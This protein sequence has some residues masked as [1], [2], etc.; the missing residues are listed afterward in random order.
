MEDP[1]STLLGHTYERHAIETWLRRHDT[2]PMT[3]S[4][5]P[6][7]MLIPNIALRQ[8]IEAWRRQEGNAVGAH[9]GL[10][11]AGVPFSQRGSAILPVEH[12]EGAPLDADV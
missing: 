11:P 6:D 8:T 2:D 9:A 7:K 10:N 1:V 5:L 3:N 12:E 4:V